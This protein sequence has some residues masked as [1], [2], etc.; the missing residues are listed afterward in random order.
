MITNAKY[1]EQGSVIATIDGLEMTVPNDMANRHRAM[2]AEWEAA[3][4]VIEPYAEPEPIDQLTL[5][6][7]KR[8]MLGVLADMGIDAEPIID[9]AIEAIEHTQTR[10][11]YRNDWRYAGGFV[12][13]HPLFNDPAF[14][15][16]L[17]M[18]S[19]QID[20]LWVA[21]QSYPA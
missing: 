3:G 1:T 11:K 7:S 10:A 12:R 17:E 6:I 4:N 16:L 15:A 21:A 8:Q 2:L 9:G 20:T 18:T 14:M 5:P 19:E 13:Q